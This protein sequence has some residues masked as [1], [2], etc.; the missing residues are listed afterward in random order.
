MEIALEKPTPNYVC[1]HISQLL[2]VKSCYTVEVVHCP[3]SGISSIS[4]S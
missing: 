3:G 4:F 1:A 2:H